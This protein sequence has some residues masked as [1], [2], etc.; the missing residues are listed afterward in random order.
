[1]ANHNNPIMCI[2]P[3]HR[4][5]GSDGSLIGYRGGIEIK[6]KLLQLEKSERK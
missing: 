4:V 1:M 6:V 2:I 3:C 5:I